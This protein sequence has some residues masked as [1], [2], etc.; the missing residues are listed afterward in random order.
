MHDHRPAGFSFALASCFLVSLATAQVEELRVLDL[1]I[2]TGA[3]YDAGRG[4]L[5]ALGWRGTTSEFDGMLWR[6]RPVPAFA[7]ADGALVS[8][9]GLAGV[10]MV[11][12][13][14]LGTFLTSRYDGVRWQPLQPALSP[15]PRRNF[16]V[17]WDSLRNQVVLFGGRDGSTVLDETWVFTGGTW[18]QR[19]PAAMP[20]PRAASGMVFDSA[21]GRCVLFGGGAN[22]TLLQDTWEWDGGT[23][24]PSQPANRPGARSGMAMAYDPLRAR[25]VL[26]GGVDSSHQ[27]LSDLWEY[28]G[29]IWQ[30]Q[31]PTGLQP[32]ARVGA[33]AV[34]DPSRG[35]VVLLGGFAAAPLFRD[36]F[37]WNGT[38]WS[39][40]P[41]APLLPVHSE[42]G[43]VFAE[44]L[45]TSLIRFGGGTNRVH[46]ETWRWDGAT[47][48]QA[49]TTGPAPR[50]DAA[51]CT[52]P[53]HG[54]LFGGEALP[55]GPLFGDLWQ[56]NGAA[57]TQLPSGP[58]ARAGAAMTFDF[59]RNEVV[60]F[61]GAAGTFLG[62]TWIWNG[63]GWQQ[64]LPSVSPS[65]RFRPGMA[66][67]AAA[68]RV[69][70]CGGVGAAPFSADTWQWDGSNWSVVPVGAAPT[71]PGT[72]T[73]AFDARRQ[74]V[75]LAMPADGI[76][77][78]L[79][80]FDGTNWNPLATTQPLPTH[81]QAVAVGSPWRSGVVF[82]DGA[83]LFGLDAAAPQA[84]AYGNPCG[85]NAPDLGANRWPQL[86]AA[87][88]GIDVVHAPPSAGVAL[89][90]ALQSANLPIAGC[91]LL[92]QPA[93]A[94]WLL[95]ASPAGNVS[96]PLPIPAQVGL[97]GVDLHLQ[98]AAL[99]PAAPPGFVMS[100]GLRVT[101][102]R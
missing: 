19:F 66:L 26:F 91:L 15:S 7:H 96:S 68:N 55:L 85:V 69:L 33:R 81:W 22:L 6:H 40:L 39:A 23:W 32:A 14:T 79:W 97:L 60:L 51:A 36:V 10:L 100:A 99:A 30:L 41:S 27:E 29:S 35:E 82:A 17:A 74:Q 98:A 52:S 76:P 67:D 54:F 58:P 46:G 11:G 72:A 70:L 71:T 13:S 37:S 62:D 50:V 1:T 53:T 57:W 80:A 56:W 84:V 89:M 18:L 61:G 5:V 77:T 8:G 24:S 88:F 102:G 86:G 34:F 64:R 87:D 44:P 31:T 3:A 16:A 73:M 28:D 49:S 93:Q 45:G 95:L 48:T 83:S 12:D 101:I 21:R 78:D 4:R 9:A 2:P 59:L 47:W 94:T 25:S 90:G 38:R 63:L 42:D 75:V 92:V 65:P 20:S 43:A